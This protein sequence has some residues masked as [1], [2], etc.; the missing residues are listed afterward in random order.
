MVAGDLDT[1]RE[2]GCV[3]ALRKTVWVEEEK[4]SLSVMWEVRVCELF[5]ES[6]YLWSRLQCVVLC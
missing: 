4:A 6:G 3:Y 5:G 1:G 2:D